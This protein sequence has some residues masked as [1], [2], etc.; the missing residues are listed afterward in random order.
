M[1]YFVLNLFILI[2]LN[3]CYSKSI[4]V[5]EKIPENVE[6]YHYKEYIKIFNCEREKSIIMGERISQVIEKI[7]KQKN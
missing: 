5:Y 6:C 7:N 3:G 1:K 2:I 4:F